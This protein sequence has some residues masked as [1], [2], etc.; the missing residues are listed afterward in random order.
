MEDEQ[1]DGQQPDQPKDSRGD[2]PAPQLS[3]S[4]GQMTAED[5]QPEEPERD[6][7]EESDWEE[8]DDDNL[9]SFEFRVETAKLLIELDEDNHAATQVCPIPRCI[10]LLCVTINMVGSKKADMSCHGAGIALHASHHW[11]SCP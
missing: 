2:K 5:G 10:T 7:D 9:P 3:S 11:L 6:A 4:E 1:G 8:E